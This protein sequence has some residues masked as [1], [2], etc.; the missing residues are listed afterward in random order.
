MDRSAGATNWGTIRKRALLMCGVVAGPLFMIVSIVQGVTRQ[1]FNLTHQPISFLS[2]GSLGWLQMSNFVVAGLLVMVFSIGV[3]QTLRS[4]AGGSGR[5]FA[6]SGVGL[7]LIIA[8]LFHPDPGFGYPQGTPEG[9]PTTITYHS[10]MH[11][12]GFTLSFVFFVIACVVFARAEAKQRRWL[13]VVYT[14]VS[15]V[16]SLVLALWP[17]NDGIALRDLFAAVFLWAWMTVHAV[18]FLRSPRPASGRSSAE[19]V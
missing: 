13:W 15:A 12:V 10:Q 11:G 19:H 17:G 6:V 18:W 16:A 2:L 14:A 8:G 5:P 9:A 1:S 3:R 4:E 7:G